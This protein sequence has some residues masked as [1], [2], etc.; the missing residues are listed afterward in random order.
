MRLAHLVSVVFIG[1]LAICGQAAAAD[2]TLPPETLANLKAATVFLKVEAG[3]DRA[4]GSG[5]VIK[6]E[7]QTAFVVTNYHVIAGLSRPKITAVFGSGTRS[8]QAGTAQVVASDSRRDLAVLRIANLK[9]APKPIDMSQQP[10]LLETMPLFIFGYPLGEALATNKGNPAITVGKGSVS[11]IRLKDS[12]ELATVQID[13]DITPGNSGGPVVSAQGQLVGVAQ[14]TV[15]DRRI[16]FAIPAAELSGLL[17]GRLLDHYFVTNQVGGKTEVRVELGV[18]DPFNRI[19]GV[20]FYYVPGD[21]VAEKKLASV[22]GVV[23]V[24]LQKESTQLAGKFTIDAPG[25]EAPVTFQAV[26][27]DGEG[28]TLITNPRVRKFKGVTKVAVAKPPPDDDDKP[29]PKPKPPVGKPTKPDPEP[30]TEKK[31]VTTTA[32]DKLPVPKYNKIPMDLSAWKRT[33]TIQKITY[34]PENEELVFLVKAKK[35]FAFTDDGYDHPFEFLDEDGVNMTN[36]KNLKWDKDPK[37]LRIGEATRV[38]LSLP[39]EEIL[40]KTKKTQAVVQGFF[41]KGN[42]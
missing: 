31:G 40:D 25:A 21:K 13:G 5:F 11:S 14:A 30:D 39:D 4:S 15:R 7:G 32:T 19:K 9:D 42:K 37:G 1:S 27:S 35:N 22:P 41:N 23:K 16:G 8:E 36:V 38:H 34:D 18:F 12:G 6:S 20:T 3:S 29:M 28:K 33:F 17:Q 24:S 26:Y 2:D 10:K